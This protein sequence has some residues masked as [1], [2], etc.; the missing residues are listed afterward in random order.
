MAG[1]RDCGEGAASEA[2]RHGQGRKGRLH[3]SWNRKCGFHAN[4]PSWIEVAHRIRGVIGIDD[5]VWR[6]GGEEFVVVCS[7]PDSLLRG[8]KVADR[9][10]EIVAEPIGDGNL[11]LSIGASVGV[12]L[13]VQPLIPTLLLKQADRA[14]FDAKNAGKN[15]VC[16]AGPAR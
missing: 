9:I 1:H 4:L 5:V 11:S 2:D 6:I 3:A 12:A 15:T 16:V 13:G 10:V 14:L 8:R 7:G